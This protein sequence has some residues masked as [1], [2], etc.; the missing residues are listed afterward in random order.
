MKKFYTKLLLA[1][2]K[3]YFFKQDFKNLFRDKVATLKM[4]TESR[5]R[6][7]KPP[8]DLQYYMKDV[9]E[10]NPQMTM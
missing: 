9:N 7:W 1:S 2:V 6:H 5:L 8:Y 4:L 3:F 10:E